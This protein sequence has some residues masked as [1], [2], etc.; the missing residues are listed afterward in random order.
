[1]PM[2]KQL[3]KLYR[4]VFY[5][6]FYYLRLSYMCKWTR[7][8]SRRRKNHAHWQR[9]GRTVMSVKRAREKKCLN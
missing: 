8:L 7:A 4:Q 9:V 6:L 2:N 3:T 5:K 1:M